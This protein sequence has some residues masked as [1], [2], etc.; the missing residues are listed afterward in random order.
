MLAAAGS[1][2]CEGLLVVAGTSVDGASAN[3]SVNLKHF[4]ASTFSFFGV[5]WTANWAIV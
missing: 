4:A 2:N 3:M 5:V 1:C